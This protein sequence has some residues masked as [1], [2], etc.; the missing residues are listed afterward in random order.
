MAT[1]RLENKGV[2]K[3]I[4]TATAVIGTSV[5]L[6]M[7]FQAVSA[8]EQEKSVEFENSEFT[9]VGNIT[10]ELPGSV[11]E[12]PSNQTEA[13]ATVEKEVEVP[14]NQTE[15]DFPEFPVPDWLYNDIKKN[16]PHVLESNEKTFN[17]IKENMPH[18]FENGIVQIKGYTEEL[19]INK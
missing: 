4:L 5:L 1:N 16:A 8:S 13:E 9:E 3:M 11:V 17:Y 18:V 7:G 10:P 6:F 19:L 14:F 15:E 2:K 12:V